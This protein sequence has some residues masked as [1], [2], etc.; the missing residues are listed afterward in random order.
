MSIFTPDTSIQLTGNATNAITYNTKD[1]PNIAFHSFAGIYN[2]GNNVIKIFT[3]NIDALTIDNN[4]K[5]ICNG[6]L[7]TN[8]DWNKIDGKPTNFQTTWSLV[9]SKP[10]IFPTNWANVDGKPTIFATNWDNVASKPSIFPTNWDNVASKPTNFQTDWDTTVLNKPLIFTQAQTSN[11][12]TTSNVIQNL[13]DFIPYSKLAGRPSLATVATSGLYND[14][15]GRPTLATVATSG[16]FNDLSGR[17]SVYP[18]DWTNVASK[19]TN[20]QSDWTSTVI[21]KPSLATV[22][23]SGLYSDLSGKPDIF[24][25]TEMSNIFITSN[26]LSNTSNTLYNNVNTTNFFTKT[27]M[28]NIFITSNVLSNTSNTLANYNNLYNKPTFNNYWSINSTSGWMYN[29]TATQISINDNYVFPGYTLQVKGKVFIEGTRLNL[30]SYVI[31]GEVISMYF[32]DQQTGGGDF[33]GIQLTKGATN[34]FYILNNLAKSI[35]F[36]T[37]GYSSMCLSSAGN[38]ALGYNNLIA[39]ARL[40]LSP[41]SANGEVKLL[42]NDGNTGYGA[43]NGCAIIKQTDQNMN[44]MNYQNNDIIFSTNGL[45][46]MR[47]N[48][49]GV[50]NIPN[51]SI[52]TSNFV[53]ASI[54]NLTNTNAN[55]TNATITNASLANITNAVV[56]GNLTLP[57]DNGIKTSDGLTRLYC[58]SSGFTFINALT[59]IDFYTNNLNK[60]MTLNQYGQLLITPDTSLTTPQGMLHLHRG[61]NTGDAIV[62]LTDGI[63]GSGATNGV[64]L[65]KETNNNCRLWNYQNAN[66]IFGTNNTERA[67][68]LSSGGFSVNDNITIGDTNSY[69]KI[70][71]KATTD[72][73]SGLCINASSTAT[74]VNTLKI[75]PWN[76]SGAYGYRFRITNQNTAVDTNCLMI[77]GNGNLWIPTSLD[78]DGELIITGEFRPNVGKWHRTRLDDKNRFYFVSSGKTIYGSGDG[79]FEWQSTLGSTMMMLSDV[80]FLGIG[81]NVPQYKLEVGSSAGT[82][83][84]IR[85]FSYFNASSGFVNNNNSS[86]NDVMAKVNGSLW[87]TSWIASSCDIRIKKEIED[88]NDD[89]AL[90]KILMIKPKKYKYIDEVKNGNKKIY[91]FIAQDLKEVLPEA[92]QINDNKEIIPNIYKVFNIENDIIT[93]DEDLRDKLKVNDIIEIVYEKKEGTKEVSINTTILEITD[94]YIKVDLKETEKSTE[95]TKVFLYGKEVNDFHTISKEYI[96][97]LNVCATQE[98][99]RIIKEQQSIINDLKNRIEILENKN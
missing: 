93:T 1:N 53:N 71:I 51:F 31:G 52:S 55:I 84:G 15:S 21:N 81:A 77:N 64:V 46:R 7:I 16:L 78:V 9:D 96:F 62:R 38:L 58:S 48:A 94:T 73:N 67:K 47:I 26:V 72:V 33:N 3:N 68:I 22:A 56:S 37:S 34:D 14:L 97:T 25:K 44:I 66:L 80:G 40:H 17:P 75:V 41:N 20:F 11:I 60:T 19:P 69:G 23:T 74:D 39:N 13:Q 24:T 43:N 70:T 79:N 10:S 2:S 45:E 18:T 8:L 35:Y 87:A 61:G 63:S 91:G 59:S 12:F 86:F 95:K 99:Y 57:F 42:L 28:S 98:L 83:T 30:R 6:S 27:E 82:T 29:N 32:Q 5:V 49:N 85:A 88:I 65:W 89:D 76:S 54:T 4:Q 90:Q 50:V 92:V 36:G